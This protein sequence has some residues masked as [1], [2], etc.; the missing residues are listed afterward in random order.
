MKYVQ[1]AILAVAG[2]VSVAASAQANNRF[3][4]NSV[5]AYAETKGVSRET[6]SLTNTYSTTAL[7][8]I[9][10]PGSQSARNI[11]LQARVNGVLNNNITSSYNST[12]DL[13]VSSFVQK[14]AAETKT[15][16]LWFSADVNGDVYSYSKGTN[17]FTQTAVSGVIANGDVKTG[18]IVL[19]S[20]VGGPVTNKNIGSNNTSVV[21][22]SSV[23]AGR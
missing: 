17:N 13:A 12:T 22:V 3:E 18:N 8:S 2:L 4:A 14:S 21:A 6:D 11:T 19:E 1:F 20:K 23:L 9:I 10:N 5:W 16:D 7:T 15:N